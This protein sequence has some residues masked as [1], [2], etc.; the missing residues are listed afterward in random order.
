[1]PRRSLALPRSMPRGS[2]VESAVAEVHRERYSRMSLCDGPTDRR[3]FFI[4]SPNRPLIQIK[5][6]DFAAPTLNYRLS[7]QAQFQDNFSQCCD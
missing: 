3:G 2:V 4:E 5:N 6:A 7:K 1:M